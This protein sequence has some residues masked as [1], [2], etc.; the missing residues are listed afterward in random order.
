MTSPIVPARAVDFDA[1][2]AWIRHAE[3]QRDGFVS[4]FAALAKEMLPS[5]TVVK[6]KSRGLFSRTRDVVAVRVVVES[7]AF[8]LSLEDGFLQSSIEQRVRGIT[9]SDKNVPIGQWMEMFL[10]EIGE[11]AEFARSFCDAA[12]KGL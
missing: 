1:A 12:A 7:C 9:L 5:Q 11:Q 10:S 6:T 8:K 3:Q 4:R 2:S